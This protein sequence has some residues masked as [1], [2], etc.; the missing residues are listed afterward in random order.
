M[1][2][3]PV[4]LGGCSGDGGG[5]GPNQV[6][7]TIISCD[8]TTYAA[9]GIVCVDFTATGPAGTFDLLVEFI[10][11]TAGPLEPAY[12]IPPALEQ[13]LGLTSSAQNYVLAFD[14]DTISGRFCWYAGADL[15]FVDAFGVQ[16][17]LTP[18]GDGTTTPLGGVVSC[19]GIN[20]TGGGQTS[21]GSNPPIG[22]LAGRAG[23]CGENVSGKNIAIAGGYTSSGPG[24]LSY[25]TVDRFTFDTANFTY[26]TNANPLVMQA[27][28]SDHACAFFLD[29]VTEAIKVLITGGAN[30]AGG[31]G[32]APV[33]SADVYCFSP[34]E[35]VQPTTG[36]LNVARRGHTATWVP[37]N[38]VIVI[39]GFDGANA[40]GSIEIYDPVVDTF[41]LLLSPTLSFPRRGHTAT[42]LPSGKVLIAG[43]FDP[44]SPSTPLPA[45]LFN[46]ANSSIMTVAGPVVDR[47]SHTA[48]RL[49]NGW[50]LLAGGFTVSSNQT[51]VSSSAQIFEPELG[52]MGQF[53]LTMPLM[54]SPR[55]LHASTLLGSGDAILTGGQTG[56]GPPFVTQTAELFLYHTLTFTP[57]IPMAV[58]RSEHSSNATN[59]GAVIVIG[60]R[61][62]VGGTNNFL[63]SLEFYPFENTNPVV[64]SAFT[65]TTG[66][67]GTV[68]ILI[69]VTDADADG[70]YVIIRFRAPVGTGMFRLATIDQ[71]S[72]STAPANFPNMQVGGMPSQA[73]PY[74]FRWNFAADGLSSGQL[75][76]IEVL[77]VGATLGSPVNFVVA[78]P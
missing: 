30:F 61:N 25:D 3:L 51:T 1:A 16:L 54:T 73:L 11:G 69:T 4:M 76:E 34:T 53:T 37:S 78:L 28:R 2:T 64:A 62:D 36:P 12:E 10:G 38:K 7:L 24:F 55:A 75:V 26:S 15:G 8:S 21:L 48:T 20:Y 31:L 35:N 29:P 40:L 6:N 67:N 41:Q 50:V 39:G 5:G 70:G 13:Q 52:G 46:P 65:G 43:G 71:Q 45:E 74:S 49:A 66:V 63:G 59:C 17:Y 47:V 19:T 77:P 18:V 56:F 57:V 58:P 68:Y 60:G 22:G 27:P 42:L 23:Q 72:P 32:A 14:G 9:F 44:A 33:G